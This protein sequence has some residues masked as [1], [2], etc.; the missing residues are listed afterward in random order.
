MNYKLS[1]LIVDPRRRRFLR[2]VIFFS[3]V[4]LIS[5]IISIYFLESKLLNG[6]LALLVFISFVIPNFIGFKLIGKVEIS[7]SK[8]IITTDNEKYKCYMLSDID[9]L[10]LYVNE[11]K[12][13]KDFVWNPLMI[14]E[15]DGVNNYLDV[16]TKTG[17][18]TCY[19]LFFGISEINNLNEIYS[20]SREGIIDKLNIYQNGKNVR[21]IKA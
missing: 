10:K 8:I 14:Y 11:I 5:L 9:R 17:K 13:R 7:Y 16:I 18:K 2:I 12:G 21:Q 3:I 6:L 15:Q 20:F 4:L 1:L 19:E